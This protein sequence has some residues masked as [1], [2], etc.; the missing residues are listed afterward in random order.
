[1]FSKKGSKRGSVQAEDVLTPAWGL[2]AVILQTLTVTV[3]VL[4]RSRGS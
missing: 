2:G 3:T 4:K 1:M